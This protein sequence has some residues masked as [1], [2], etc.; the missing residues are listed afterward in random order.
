MRPDFYTSMVNIHTSPLDF[1]RTTK[2]PKESANGTRTATWASTGPQYGFFH[3]RVVQTGTQYAAFGA[4]E[5]TTPAK[6]SLCEDFNGK[7]GLTS[8]ASIAQNKNLSSR[9][10][11]GI[12]A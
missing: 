3:L 1:M 8:A 11:D 10:A 12:E 4:R 7:K 9:K 2:F 5:H 6:N